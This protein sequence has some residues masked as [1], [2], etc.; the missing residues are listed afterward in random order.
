M[1][2]NDVID[3]SFVDLGVIQPGDSITTTLRTPAQVQL[4]ALLSSLST[5]QLTAFQQVMQVFN[6][7]AGQTAYTLGSGGSFATTGGLRAMRVTAWR[8]AYANLLSSGGRVLS[9]DEFGA[10]AQQA[11]PAGETA[12]IPKIVGAD[13]SYPL[14][15]VR[16]LPP[17]GSFP[18]TLELAYYTPLTQI[19]DFTVALTL[20]DGWLQMLHWNLAEQLYSQYARPGQTIDVIAAEAQKSKAALVAQNSMSAIQGAAQ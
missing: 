12:P 17:P 14:I 7:V 5:E 16:V 20:P 2:G 15:N 4:N 1:T 10:A 11:Q 3:Q 18:G 9:M 19:T 13:T 6:L 8:A